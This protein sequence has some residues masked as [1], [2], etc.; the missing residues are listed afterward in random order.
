MIKK[1]WIDN[2]KAFNNLDVQ[3]NP[4]NVIVGNN[5]S[6]KSSLLFVL[7]FL[8]NSTKNDFSDFLDKR[9]L[10]VD[11]IKSKF[12]PTNNLIKFIIDFEVLVNDEVKKL[13]WGLYINADVKS[14]T[15]EL[16]E[17]WVSDINEDYLR[18]NRNEKIFNRR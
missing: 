14:N 8:S 1:L 9:H 7:S 4:I 16:A 15:V 13:N 12:N 5:A 6:G 10:K 18:Y 17:D 3:L 2:F 11:N